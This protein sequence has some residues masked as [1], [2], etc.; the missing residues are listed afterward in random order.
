MQEKHLYEYAVIRVLPRVEREEFLNVGIILFSKG[1]KFIKVLYTIDEEKLRLFAD[2]LDVD[3]LRLNM[4][5]F[6]KIARG[7]KDGGPIAQMDIPSRFR[8]LTAVRSSV[9]QTSRPHPGFCGNLEGTIERLFTELV[10]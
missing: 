5:S 3:Q 7:D 10:L 6:E 9:I 2:D 4:E 1:A 8:W